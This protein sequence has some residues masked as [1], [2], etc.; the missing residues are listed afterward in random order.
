VLPG[1]SHVGFIL[2]VSCAA[3]GIARTSRAAEATTPP[4][5][6]PSSPAAPRPVALYISGCPSVTEDGVRRIVAV[7][8]GPRLLSG[9]SP[10]P[11]NVD[12]LIVSCR[13]QQAR[14]EAGDPASPRYAERTLPLDRFPGDGGTRA[15]ALA[16]LELLVALDRP[17]TPPPSAAAV[18]EYEQKFVWFYDGTSSFGREWVPYRGKY[19][20]PLTGSD[21][22]D[23]IGR[24]D[25]AT[26]YHVRQA[27]NITM[28]VGGTVLFFY[29]LATL[30]AG[31]NGWIGLGCWIGG[32]L[33]G[34]TGFYRSN[35][36]V[37]GPAARRLADEHNKSLKRQLGLPQQLNPDQSPQPV[38][39]GWHVSAVVSPAG[40]A[41]A[42]K[43]TF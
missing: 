30:G 14:L 38:M 23:A 21:F 10:V 39:R 5:P 6:T 43:L 12:R 17:R 40:G 2:A 19:H 42:L 32:G 8:L 29:G 36:P 13:G 1:I 9:G 7:E 27:V 28:F 33:L 31:Q 25:L 24:P 18:D 35:D 3:V 41:L 16:A 22:Y 4:A 26:G 15:V 20:E 11:P 34:A 37:D